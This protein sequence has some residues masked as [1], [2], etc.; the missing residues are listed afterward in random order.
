VRELDAKMLA[1]LDGRRRLLRDRLWLVG[2][3]ALQLRGHALHALREADALR[4]T[5]Q[6]RS[7]RRRLR[8]VAKR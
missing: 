8:L 5:I 6:Q 7:M 2:L 4:R 1:E 3:R